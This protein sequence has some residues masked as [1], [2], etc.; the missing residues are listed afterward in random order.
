MNIY[1]KI[2]LYKAAIEELRPFEGK[3]LDE[4]KAYYR[5]GLTWSSN[6]LEGNTLYANRE[7]DQGAAGGRPDH[8]PDV[9]PGH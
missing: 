7:R 8:A 3:L 9:L 6:A 1:G 4:I 5:I 2:D